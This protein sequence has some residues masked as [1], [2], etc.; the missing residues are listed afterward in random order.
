MMNHHI[1]GIEMAEHI[2]HMTFNVQIRREAYLLK[3]RLRILD[4]KIISDFFYRK[5]FLNRFKK[6]EYFFLSV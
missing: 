3:E 4:P 6:Y 1:D 5:C 2:L